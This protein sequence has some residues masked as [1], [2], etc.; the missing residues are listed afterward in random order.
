MTTV[1]LHPLSHTE[2]LREAHSITAALSRRNDID[3]EWIE[4]TFTSWVA[5][6]HNF[7]RENERGP[8]F[9]VVGCGLCVHTQL[10]IKVQMSL[11]LTSTI[12]LMPSSC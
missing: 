6:L 9:L 2:V 12:S 10:S 11:R 3:I 1:D 5:P 8:H 4:W 7:C